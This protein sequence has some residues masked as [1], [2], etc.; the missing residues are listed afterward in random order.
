MGDNLVDLEWNKIDALTG[1][2]SQWPL[3]LGLRPWYLQVGWHRV[4]DL[5]TTSTAVQP[6][7]TPLLPASRIPL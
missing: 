1:G 3:G 2:T 5:R 7:A 4:S 6:W